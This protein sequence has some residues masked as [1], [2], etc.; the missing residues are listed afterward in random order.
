MNEAIA[1][2][3]EKKHPDLIF[4][5]SDEK[6]IIYATCKGDNRIAII[7]ARGSGIKQVIKLTEKQV[8]AICQELPDLLWM[9][10]R[11]KR[12]ESRQ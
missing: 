11:G 2:R 5:E 6:N 9:I 4:A 8:I 3:L 12:G 10:G 7:E 1:I